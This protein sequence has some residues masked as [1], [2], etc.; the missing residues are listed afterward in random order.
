MANSI[1]NMLNSKLRFSGLSSGLDTDTMIKQ[2]MQIEHAKV[3][4]V[5]Q[6]KTLLEW[7]RDDYRSII[8][9]I[10]SFRDEFFD[11]IKPSTNFRS[12]SAFASYDTKSDNESIVT[13]KAGAGAASTTHNMYVKQLA[14]AASIEST[15]AMTG[16]LNG[17]VA[18]TDFTL[19]GKQIDVTLDGVRK[20]I[21]LEDYANIGDLQTKLQTAIDAAFG[22]TATNTSKINVLVNVD[23]IELKTAL[24]GSTLSVA[25]TANSYISSL[26]FSSGQQNFITGNDI[27]TVDPSTLNGK[28]KVKIGASEAEIELTGLTATSTLEDV[29]AQIQSKIDASGI[30]AGKVGVALNGN[31]LEFLTKTGEQLTLSNGSTNS[32]IYK[33]GF[34][35]GSSVT[36]T[37]S[38]DVNLSGNEKGK[39]FTLNINGVDKTIEI[40]SDYSDMTSFK[41]YIQSQLGGVSV[42]LD[43][44]GKR[45][46]FQG[47]SNE[48]I[49]IKKGP[50]DSLTKLGFSATDNKSNRVSLTSNLDSIETH[51]ST[52]VN[53]NSAANVQFTINGTNIILGKT[54]AQAT[55]NDVM[56]AINSSSA[57]VEMKYNSLED[58]FTLTSKL[59]G[60]SETIAITD[61]N[62]L[63]SALG[64]NQ[65]N[66]VAGKDAI[67]KLDNVDMQRNTNEFTIDGLTYSL[68][69]DAY[70]TTEVK[71][72]VSANATNLVDKIK[73][74]VNKYNELV[75]KINGE[76][77][78]KKERDYSPLTD[79]QKE[80]MSETDIKNWEAKAKSGLLRSDNI[81]SNIANNMRKALSDVVGGSSTSLA[82]I[83]IT[84][85]SYEMKGM[86]IVDEIKLN[87]AIKDNIDG[88]VQLFTKESQYS[89]SEAQSDSTKRTTRYNE[90]GLAQRLNDI[91]QDN[92]R[93]TRDDKGKKGILLEKA[94]IAGDLTEFNN[95]MN[96]SIE[97]KDILIDKLLDKLADKENA[98]YIKFTAMEKALSQMN[99]QSSWF[100]QQTGGGQ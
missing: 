22:K 13:V 64:I 95:L 6:D 81:L 75:S 83:G 100:S 4:R 58:K 38:V 93:T 85:G 9:S 97:E 98:L 39:T 49:I 65:S 92:I 87:A 82:K 63:F 57:G 47:N 54:F 26:G 40:D 29:R 79:E 91:I 31:K 74:F 10:R 80:S 18:I 94:G 88:V 44:T 61:T 53:F 60:V 1:S 12:P 66:L 28:F 42:N 8:N 36:G 2:L 89:Y 73:S 71:I 68:K 27:S 59:T 34:A 37:S 62:G 52:P 50:E 11:T 55:I 56:T 84:T 25:E 14:T 15:S 19:Q 86:L 48:K 77:S 32:N 70:S 21:N 17:S 72:N 23:K 78:E 7:K 43:P 41:N 51:L 69:S 24:N 46:V 96:D 5:K 67:F 90:S 35:S 30:G 45:L 20:T 16:A 3:N 99:S 76:L 33:L